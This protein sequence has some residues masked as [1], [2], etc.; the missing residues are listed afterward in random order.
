MFFDVVV[1]QCKLLTA[2][3]DNKV[4][5][6]KIFELVPFFGYCAGSINFCL[7]ETLCECGARGFFAFAVRELVKV[8]GHFELVDSVEQIFE[9]CAH[10]FGAFV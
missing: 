1:A 2:Q 9:Y 4:S 10:M 3:F 8:N 7:G 6:F 5:L